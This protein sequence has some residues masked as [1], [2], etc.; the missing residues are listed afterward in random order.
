MSI[1]AGLDSL[2]VLKAITITG[3]IFWILTLY[4]LTTKSDF[5]GIGP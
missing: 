1:V 4:A 3:A 5:T 2:M